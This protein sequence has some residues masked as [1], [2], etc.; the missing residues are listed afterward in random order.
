MVLSFHVCAFTCL[1]RFHVCDAK[2]TEQALVLLQSCSGYRESRQ[3]GCS[4]AVSLT[5]VLQFSVGLRVKVCEC[6][7]TLC[8]LV[9]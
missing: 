3:T 9:L 6:I 5:C 8:V 7:R 1:C 4:G 2:V